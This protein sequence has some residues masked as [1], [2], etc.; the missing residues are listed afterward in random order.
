MMK[1][2]HHKL[3]YFY[4]NNVEKLLALLEGSI[5]VQINS[6]ERYLCA[7]EPINWIEKKMSNYHYVLW[8]N[9][10][11]GRSYTDITQYPFVPWVL[12]GN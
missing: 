1:D 10:V 4:G 5:T 12:V 2:G 9:H 3:L 8:L 11:A 7:K 6:Y